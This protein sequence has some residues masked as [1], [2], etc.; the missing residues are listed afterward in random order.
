MP[1]SAIFQL[2]VENHFITMNDF[3]IEAKKL[4]KSYAGNQVLRDVDFH[5]RAGEIHCVVG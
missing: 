2:K 5:V 3:V 1:E 4:S